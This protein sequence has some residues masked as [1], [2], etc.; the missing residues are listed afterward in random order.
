MKMR[1]KYTQTASL[2]WRIIG[3]FSGTEDEL[4]LSFAVSSSNNFLKL[5][6]CISNIKLTNKLEKRGGIKKGK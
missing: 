6:D 3:L 4:A 5:V 1:E 2:N